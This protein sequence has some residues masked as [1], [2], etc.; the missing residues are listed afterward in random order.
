MATALAY[1]VIAPVSSEV[2]TTL[3]VSAGAAYEVVADAVDDRLDHGPIRVEQ[4]PG[5][6]ED[7]CPTFSLNVLD[8]RKTHIAI[9]DGVRIE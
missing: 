9:G 5:K 8:R 1:P 3:S 2:S 7:C 6:T 4:S